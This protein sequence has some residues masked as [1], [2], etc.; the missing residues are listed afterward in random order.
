MFTDAISPTWSELR[1]ASTL[2]SFVPARLLKSDTRNWFVVPVGIRRKL[3]T[4]RI[5]E[6]KVLASAVG[7]MPRPITAAAAVASKVFFNVF[8][9]CFS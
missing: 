1:F 9:A 2:A 3:L 7:S 4:C 5:A 6:A 8:M